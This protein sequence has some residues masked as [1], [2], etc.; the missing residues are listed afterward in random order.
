M[1]AFIQYREKL[2]STV[3][4][5]TWDSNVSK[6]ICSHIHLTT[7]FCL[8]ASDYV[9][10]SSSTYTELPSEA[11]FKLGSINSWCLKRRRRKKS[12][13]FEPKTSEATLWSESVAHMWR[14]AD[15]VAAVTSAQACDCVLSP[16]ETQ[17]GTMWTGLFLR[18][19]SLKG[20]KEPSRSRL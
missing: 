12:A 7:Q 2:H 15:T 18:R 1:V 19:R 6:N 13:S 4:N 16:G 5:L 8:F 10:R 11:T 3:Q 17:S 14:D 20:K 9:T